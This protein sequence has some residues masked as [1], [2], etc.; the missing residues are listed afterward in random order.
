MKAFQN[1]FKKGR[2]HFSI[3][4]DKGKEFYNRNVAKLLKTE[5]IKLFSTENDDIKSSVCERVIHTINNKLYKFF[6]YRQS[7]VYIDV[8]QDIVNSYNNTP[9]HAIGYKLPSEV[10]KE[11][12]ELIW[13]NKM[14][15]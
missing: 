6:Q 3:H 1:V 2:K 5:G 10:T 14:R 9:H 15:S 11:N 8:L 7:Y 4:V 12:E 13:L